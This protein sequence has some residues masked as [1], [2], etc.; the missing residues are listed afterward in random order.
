[1]KFKVCCTCKQEKTINN[2]KIQP[3]EIKD[4]NYE[5]NNNQ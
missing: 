1:M 3:N 4:K 2:L 5:R